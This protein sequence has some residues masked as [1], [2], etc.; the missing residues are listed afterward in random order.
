MESH[1]ESLLATAI[2]H[3]EESSA[4]RQ[5]ASTLLEKTKNTAM[6]ARQCLE[7]LEK[8]LSKE[9]A[10]R[11]V[12]SIDLL[13]QDTDMIRGCLDRAS[14]MVTR[15]KFIHKTALK[16]AY[17]IRM[18][19]MDSQPEVVLSPGA[20]AFLEWAKNSV[21]KLDLFNELSESER[22]A[23]RKKLG[24]ETDFVNIFTALSVEGK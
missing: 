3:L 2:S 11:V 8:H 14:S 1:I 23:I 6:V 16:R 9:D 15:T 24:K 18:Q 7:E 12:S 4:Y 17:G 19:L 5:E 10:E 22:S 20:V 21:E 13:S